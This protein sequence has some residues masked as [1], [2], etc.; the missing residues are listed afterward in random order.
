MAA[1]NTHHK[2]SVLILSLWVLMLLTTFVT[3][4]GLNVRQRIT[5]A[6][7]LE[8][9]NRLHH[10][11]EAGVK[12]AIA[13][14]RVDVKANP[15]GQSAES[16][17]ARFNNPDLFARVELDEGL[18][19]VGTESVDHSG[20]TLLQYGLMDEER[21]VNINT[22]DRNVLSQLIAL[23]SG[24]QD[25]EIYRIVE[26]IIDW[27][28]IGHSQL[29]GASSDE[30]YASLPHPYAKK[31]APFELLEEL[32]LVQGMDE[33]LYA[34]LK[35]FITIY[36]DGLVNVNTAPLQVLMA[37]GLDEPVAF[38]LMA[39]RAGVDETEATI[40]DHIFINSFDVTK[41]LSDL[42]KLEKEEV[43]QVDFLN[44]S[45]YITTSSH[46][47]RIDSSGTLG[48]REERLKISCVYNSR[49]NIIEYWREN[50]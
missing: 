20:K 27:R 13:F 10:I 39:A 33:E 37:L 45:G 32:M 47:F 7:R 50:N 28:E 29:L 11:T 42:I 36:G 9:R 35:P 48:R 38:K 49:N 24:K 19:F 16:K 46:Y 41:E 5:L 8:E 14:L 43:V 12:L 21:K 23:V 34:A 17:A 25:A 6:S 40:D 26:S 4:I 22:A 30:Y 3:V 15:A 44:A 18:A 31:D 2:G 1:K